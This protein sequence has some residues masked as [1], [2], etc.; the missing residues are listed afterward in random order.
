MNWYN[1]EDVLRAFP[2]TLHKDYWR[3]YDGL[4]EEVQKNWIKLQTAFLRHFKTDESDEF[5]LRDL[6]SLRQGKDESFSDYY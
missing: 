5:G 1:E 6:E 2:Q 4:D 3:W